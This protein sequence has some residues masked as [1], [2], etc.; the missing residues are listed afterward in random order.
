MLME[1]QCLVFSSRL[2]ESFLIDAAK[3]RGFFMY[4]HSSGSCTKKMFAVLPKPDAAREALEK[5]GS[6][7]I[8]VQLPGFEPGSPTWQAGIITKLYYNCTD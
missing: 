8:M 7:K 6:W 2:H 3:Q 5:I 4:L 1:R